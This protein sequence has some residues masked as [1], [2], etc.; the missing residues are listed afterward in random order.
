MHRKVPHRA[1]HCNHALDSGLAAKGF[2][3][4]YQQ[5]LAAKPAP[6]APEKLLT[7]S[8]RTPSSANNIVQ[9]PDKCLRLKAKQAYNNFQHVLSKLLRAR[10]A[11]NHEGHGLTTPAACSQACLTEALGL[12]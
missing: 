9:A 6:A 4:S 2:L 5:I 12:A 11:L 7:V 1:T 8:T 3:T 10:D